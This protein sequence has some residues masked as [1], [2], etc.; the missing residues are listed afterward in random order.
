MRTNEEP[1][2]LDH[3]AAMRAKDEPEIAGQWEATKIVVDI[4]K[5]REDAGLTQADV[6]AR[7]GIAQP[8]VARIE[9]RPWAASFARILAYADAVG[10]KVGTMEPERVAA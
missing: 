8:H 1:D 2:Y 9:R 4:K 7:M 3:V 5:A 10:V 6:A